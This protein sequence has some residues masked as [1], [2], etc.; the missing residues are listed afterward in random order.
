MKQTNNN[1]S[2]QMGFEQRFKSSVSSI[3][4]WTT[5]IFLKFIANYIQIYIL[6]I[7]TFFEFP[8]NI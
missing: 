5:K 7:F 1:K 6:P 2:K 4:Y 8:I 3:K